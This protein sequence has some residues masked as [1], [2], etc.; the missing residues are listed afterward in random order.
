MISSLIGVI[1]VEKIAS[2]RHIFGEMNI[3][4]SLPIQKKILEVTESMF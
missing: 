1:L 4:P 2:S 3:P